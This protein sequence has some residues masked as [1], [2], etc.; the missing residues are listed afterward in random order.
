M[1]EKEKA[2]LFESA[3]ERGIS[4]TD[5]SGFLNTLERMEKEMPQMFMSLEERFNLKEQHG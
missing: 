1:T 2:A 4:D 3:R 5:T